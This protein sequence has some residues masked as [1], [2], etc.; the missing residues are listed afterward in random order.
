M[1]C[2]GAKETHKSIERSVLEPVEPVH[3]FAEEDWNQVSI[4]EVEKKGTEAWRMHW[5]RAS[6]TLAERAAW[7]FMKEH[8]PS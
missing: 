6:K 1:S 7:D 2:F 4:D 3:T 8:N 5:Y